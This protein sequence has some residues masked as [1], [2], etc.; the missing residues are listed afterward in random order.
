MMDAATW[1]RRSALGLSVVA[2]LGSA[3]AYADDSSAQ[4][5]GMKDPRHD[6]AERN[7][8]QRDIIKDKRALAADEKSGANS[9]QVAADK[10][11]LHADQL[12][13]KRDRR[14]IT[15]DQ[16]AHRHRRPHP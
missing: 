11:A 6:R 5:Q 7:A 4:Q 12:D 1:I 10:K 8:D 13:R 3:A 15:Q 9:A 14:G 2:V 16:R